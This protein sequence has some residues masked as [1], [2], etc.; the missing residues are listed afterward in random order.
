MGV[1]SMIRLFVYSLFG[2]WAFA[3]GLLVFYALETALPLEGLPLALVLMCALAAVR[4]YISRA[5]FERYSI[6]TVGVFKTVDRHT[7]EG[8]D[9][10]SYGDCTDGTENGERRVAVKEY[11]VLGCPVYR[12]AGAVNRYCPTH[13]S[14]E[15]RQQEPDGDTTD[16]NTTTQ[17]T[18]KTE[19]S[20]SAFSGTEFSSTT[21]DVFPLLPVAVLILSVLP[22]VWLIERLPE[23][24]FS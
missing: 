23:R 14:F 13:S 22:F 15:F 21:S 11:V 6:A 24:I 3:G 1:C 8:G 16:A 12:R 7:A 18:S 20:H 17:R 4:A 9:E 2:L 5:D 10:C 19:L